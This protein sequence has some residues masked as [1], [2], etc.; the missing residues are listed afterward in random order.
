MKVE[1]EGIYAG[2][3]G[4]NLVFLEG[5]RVIKVKAEKVENGVSEGSK[6]LVSAEGV[7]SVFSDYGDLRLS[8]D[9]LIVQGL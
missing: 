3:K 8:V 6:V 1:F 2:S 7:K 5:T 9:S 4:K